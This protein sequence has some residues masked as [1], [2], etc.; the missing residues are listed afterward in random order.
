M[1]RAWVASGAAA[2]APTTSLTS[3]TI[4]NSN[5]TARFSPDFASAFCPADGWVLHS[6][7]RSDLEWVFA[8]LNLTFAVQVGLDE[9]TC[10]FSV[11]HCKGLAYKWRNN[12]CY[13]RAS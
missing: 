3:A 13:W 12:M 7:E 6:R 10:L 5:P 11:S 1:L 4:T 8:R 2:S 9:V